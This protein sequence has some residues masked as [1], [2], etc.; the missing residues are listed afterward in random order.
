[1]QHCIEALEA[2]VAL[3]MKQ[4]NIMME[5]QKIAILEQKTYCEEL[6]RSQKMFQERLEH[7]LKMINSRQ[8]M[9]KNR[10][11]MIFTKQDQIQSTL[12]G[13]TPPIQSPSTSALASMSPPLTSPTA[14]V[15]GFR[16][17]SKIPE[18]EPRRTE[19]TDVCSMLSDSDLESLLSL[20]WITPFESQS[21]AATSLGTPH[22]GIVSE[23]AS[24]GIFQ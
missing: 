15:A 21:N 17:S 10:Q 6:D 18:H 4:Q 12:H 16:T 23:T 3:L 20:D 9:I 2:S 13:E 14:S 8:D 22:L 24:A 5:Q 11:E 19:V 1:M 7:E